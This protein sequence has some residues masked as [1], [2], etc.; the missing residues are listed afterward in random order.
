MDI[1]AIRIKTKID[2]KDASSKLLTLQNSIVK[3]A[4]KT[5]KTLDELEELGKLKIP[6]EQYKALCEEIEKGQKGV[7]K[8]ETRLE[9]LNNKLKEL[10]NTKVKTAEYAELEQDL[11]AVDKAT[12]KLYEKVTKLSEKGTYN[13]K[14]KAAEAEY[15][16]MR[17]YAEHIQKQISELE[18]N[19][20]VF[21]DQTQ[22]DKYKKIQKEI[23]ECTKELEEFT[24]LEEKRVSI[25]E[26]GTA[27][28]DPTTTDAY[29]KKAQEL[30][31][32]NREMEILNKKHEELAA[33]QDEVND[34]SG[35]LLKR[36]TGLA[37]GVFVF[38]QITKALNTMLSA[39]KEGLQDMSQ[40]SDEYNANMSQFSSRTTELKYNLAAMAEPVLNLLIPAF[41]TL[42]G[43]INTAV[44][45]VTKFL[46]AL[47]GKNTYTK[48]KKQVIDY[49]KGVAKAGEET[50]GA[51]ADFDDLNVLNQN[52]GSASA[53]GALSGADAFEEVE[54]GEM[55]SV[56]EKIK[57]M[58]SG[59]WE[60]LIKPFT[61][62]KE[63]FIEVF[64]GLKKVVGTVFGT[65][66]DTI[67]N[68]FNKLSE[69]YNAHIK[70]FIDSVISGL[71]NLTGKF[72]EFWNNCVMPVLESIAAKFDEVMSQHIQPL[73]DRCLDLVGSIADLLKVFWEEVLQ[74]LWAWIIENIFPVIMPIIETVCNGVMEFLGYTA[75]AFGGLLEILQGIIDF[76]VGVFIGDWDKAWEAIGN[77]IQGIMDIIGSCINAAMDY[78]YTEFKLGLE[79]IAGIVK[80]IFNGIG[81]FIGWI[82][83]RIGT[84]IFGALGSIDE[85]WY[86][87]WDCMREGVIE[88][89]NG[90]WDSLREIIN[91]IIEGIETMAN[92]V[93]SAVN[94]M[95]Q[96]INN[97]S[98]S[99]PDWIPAL[100]GKSFSLNLRTIDSINIPRLANGGITTGSTIANI[101]EAGREAVLPLENNL[102]YLDAFADKIAGKMGNA[103]GAVDLTV[104]LDGKTVYKRMVQLD[105]EFA[106]RTGRSQFAY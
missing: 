59:V 71:S 93:I 9:G 24:K 16:E 78:I 41:T 38:S 79:I 49:A 29:K 28:I 35:K 97:M 61:E 73:I 32:C 69:V 74:P 67:N 68:T 25:E 90:M 99:I 30:E 82:L 102:D 20:K 43:W 23:E 63:A 22:T 5:D 13:D 42:T 6:T 44:E 40:Y 62:N 2:T 54:V 39:M 19:G 96:A 60:A 66:S 57:E 77:I 47:S 48:A 106:G 104:N 33:K 95:I 88:T 98:F 55:F 26:S 53:N 3:L 84:I 51:L 14:Y 27:F 34:G 10:E 87:V 83:D 21:V 7:Q 85:R 12:E 58:L 72:L 56:I 8:T 45:A 36:I 80:V 103:A 101:G 37:S 70:P 91:S 86:A 4:E 75:D 52:S 76:I 50:K 89:W 18:K 46:S 100:G 17:E 15:M 105:R 81:D 65:I 64:E 1:A 92:A 94:G 31:A 11:C